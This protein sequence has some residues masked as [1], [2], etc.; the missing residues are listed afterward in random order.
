M[1]ERRAESQ[2]KCDEC[3]GTGHVAEASRLARLFPNNRVHCF[4]S[5]IA[6]APQL[7]LLFMLNR[8]VCATRGA[9]R[10]GDLIRCALEPG[11][12]LA[13][14]CRVFLRERMI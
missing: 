12:Q 9:N 1:P 14:R 2:T 3:R 6:S 13:R 10:S 11:R 8:H 5:A 7:N 4:S